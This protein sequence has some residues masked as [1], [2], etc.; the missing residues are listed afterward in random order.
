MAKYSGLPWDCIISA[1]LFGHYKPDP[2]T[3]LGSAQLLDLDPEQVM[4]CAAHKDDLLAAQAC[5]LKTAFIKRPR[6]FAPSVNLDLSFDKRFD[7]NA[8]SVT[9]LADQLGSS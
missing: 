5:G 8:D 9:D 3:Y 1:E 7:F 6:E 2:E 4:L